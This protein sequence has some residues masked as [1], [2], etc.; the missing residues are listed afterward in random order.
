MAAELAKR[1]TV[2]VGHR[3]AGR[4]RLAASGGDGDG[5]RRGSPPCQLATLQQHARRAHRP[6]GA[7]AA[8]YEMR[9]RATVDHWLVAANR[10][11][12]VSL[13]PFQTQ[14]GQTPRRPRAQ[15]YEYSGAADVAPCELHSTSAVAA[16]LAPQ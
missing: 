15:P 1:A 12:L 7:A 9:G 16:Q 11:Q 5:C 4:H 2:F 8:V 14:P 3:S 10:H 6:L 13:V